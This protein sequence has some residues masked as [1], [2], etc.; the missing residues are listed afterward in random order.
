MNEIEA[1]IRA[2]A[3]LYGIDPDIAV[4]IAMAEGG[5]SNPTRQ[6]DVV[7]NGV[8]ETSYGPFQ[9]RIGGGLGDI[10]LSKGI[11]PRKE[12]F[13]RQGVDLA[14]STAGKQGWGQWYGARDNGIG[15]WEGIK[16]Y[17]GGG[18]T[19]GISINSAPGY[20]GGGPTGSPPPSGPVTPAPPAEGGGLTDI[21]GG[22][23]LG[24]IAK[25]FGGGQQTD[26]TLNQIAPSSIGAEVGSGS[27]AAAAAQLLTA[28]LDSR[29]RRHGISLSG[30]NGL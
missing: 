30:A 15:N 29:R 4:R 7:K 20:V 2:R 10:A 1:Y 9:L 11:D 17:T 13:W 6:S 5:L 14:L 22:G 8:R 25:S 19:G 23:K 3:P 24:D 12:E 18:P 28:I 26:P 16:G 21:L 27:G